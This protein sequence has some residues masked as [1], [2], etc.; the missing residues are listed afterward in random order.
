MRL[1]AVPKNLFGRIAL[2]AGVVPTP[3]GDTIVA[4]TLARTIMVATKLGIFE[5][6]GKGACT[7]HEIAIRCGGLDQHA[8]EAL[9]FALDG[10]GYVRCKEMR[11]TLAPVAKK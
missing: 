9:L 6:L 1:N 7:T 3:L 5:A 11:Y 10:A 8:T 4:M 2:R